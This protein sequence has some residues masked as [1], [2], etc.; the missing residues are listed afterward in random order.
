ML[1]F[2]LLYLYYLEQF[3]F[4]TIFSNLLFGTCITSDSKFHVYPNQSIICVGMKTDSSKLGK[5]P[6]VIK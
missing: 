4:S 5:N 2:L 3:I 1:V 6:V